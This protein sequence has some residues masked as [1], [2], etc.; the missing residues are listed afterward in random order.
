MPEYS[1]ECN[2]CKKTFSVSCSISD[3]SENRIACVYCS[4]HEITRD[5]TTDILGGYF[6]V[7]KHDSELK[8]I[9]DLAN[10][11]S[12]RF[13]EDKKNHLFHKHNEYRKDSEGKLP[14]GMT[15]IKKKNKINWRGNKNGKG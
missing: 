12:D 7:K 13:S 4:S 10:R 11:N 8:T 9:G 2:N 1:F 6:A 3:Y 14:D 15:R 5:F